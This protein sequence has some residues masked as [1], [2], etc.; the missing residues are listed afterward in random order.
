MVEGEAPPLQLLLFLAS[1]LHSWWREEALFY[2][3]SYRYVLPKIR[4]QLK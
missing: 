3:F 1:S 2:L 4:L